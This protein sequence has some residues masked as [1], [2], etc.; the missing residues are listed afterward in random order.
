MVPLAG[1]RI[2]GDPDSGLVFLTQLGFSD[3]DAVSLW[4]SMLAYTVGFSMFSSAY[5]A[6]DTFDLP[7]GLAARMADWR[8]E[9]CARTIR[10]IIEGYD[11]QRQA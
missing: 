10:M 8:D 5:A 3:D 7:P 11:A 9:T 4:Q 2:E 6:S 1:R